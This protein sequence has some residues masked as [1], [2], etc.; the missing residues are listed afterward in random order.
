MKTLK[1]IDLTK[2]GEPTYITYFYH[3]DYKIVFKVITNGNDCAIGIA[4]ECGIN[5]NMK[6]SN[7]LPKYII[8]SLH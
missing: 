1:E 4:R 8:N 6:F 3:K 5:K 7:K 2:Q